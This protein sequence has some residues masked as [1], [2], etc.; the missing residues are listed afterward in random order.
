ML[1]LTRKAR[2][3]IMIGDD[4]EV[5]IIGLISHEKVRVGIGAPSNLRVY[6]K[7][8][9]DDIVAHQSSVV[10]PK[11]HPAT[12]AALAALDH[13]LSTDAETI[14]TDT[15]RELRDAWF[16]AA[17]LQQFIASQNPVTGEVVS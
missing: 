15:I 3:S 5:A 10:P 17:R 16:D 4:I 8:L 9:Y 2:E 14:Q 7:E 1:V 13:L 12:G 6:R 11:E